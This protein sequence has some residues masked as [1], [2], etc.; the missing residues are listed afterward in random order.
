M[1]ELTPNQLEAIAEGAIGQGLDAAKPLVAGLLGKAGT[2]GEAIEQPLWALVE[3]A[4][5]AGVEFA[6][7]QLT[8]QAMDISTYGRVTATLELD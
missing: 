6:V 1:P 7:Q 8:P 3:A 5:G 2:I 4:I